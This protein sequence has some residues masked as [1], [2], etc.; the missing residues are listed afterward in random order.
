MNN[1]LEPKQE[2][3][4]QVCGK[5]KSECEDWNAYYGSCEECL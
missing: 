5:L 4:C 2:E 3:K 1:T